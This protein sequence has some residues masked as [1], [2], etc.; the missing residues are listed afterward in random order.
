[1]N[2]RALTRRLPSTIPVTIA[3]RPPNMNRS[4]VEPAILFKTAD[5]LGHVLSL[6]TKDESL[7]TTLNVIVELCVAFDLLVI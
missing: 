7:G 6:S 4:D 5:E 3:R 2:L 1:M